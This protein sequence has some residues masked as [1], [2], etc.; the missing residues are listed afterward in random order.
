MNPVLFNIQKFSIHDGAGI[1][2][3]VFFKGCPLHC[4][5]C[6]NPESQRY[7]RELMY[8]A[9]RCV[10]CG[11]C[12]AACPK[13]AISPDIV[14]DRTVCDGCGFCTSYCL[15]NAREQVVYQKDPEDL[16]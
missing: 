1:R 14:T 7:E 6:H 3:T 10:H 8:Y 16:I 2:T 15:Y 5:W 9:D 12:A 13:G 11:A 4:L